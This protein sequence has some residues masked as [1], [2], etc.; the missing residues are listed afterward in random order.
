M[1]LKRMLDGVRA[2]IARNGVGPG[3]VGVVAQGGPHPMGTTGQGTLVNEV[4]ASTAQSDVGP[5]P[6]GEA[7]ALS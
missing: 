1:N 4:G 7:L 2:E 6:D 5:V 3:V